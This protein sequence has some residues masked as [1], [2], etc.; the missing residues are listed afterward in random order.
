M[1]KILLLFFV[2]AHFIVL[3][4]QALTDK[5]ANNIKN[6][7]KGQVIVHISYASGGYQTEEKD[8][9]TANDTNP[10]NITYSVFSHIKD[11]LGVFPDTTYTLT[12]SQITMLNNYFSAVSNGSNPNTGLPT[13][14]NASSTIFFAMC[15]DGQV[16]V[17]WSGQIHMTL[18]RYL[19]ADMNNWN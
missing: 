2:A 9:I 14:Q 17:I 1:K 3:G 6:G 11:S 5:I 15:C 7:G 13:V 12:A 10:G 16:N 4:Q 18:A 19:L 8:V